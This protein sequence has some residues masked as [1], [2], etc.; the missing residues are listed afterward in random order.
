MGLQIGKV[1][2]IFKGTVKH[3]AP[4]QGVSVVGVNRSLTQSDGVTVG[5]LK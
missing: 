5:N 4:N 3:I 2:P 1:S